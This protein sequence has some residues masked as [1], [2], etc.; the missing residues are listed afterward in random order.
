MK[1]PKFTVRLKMNYSENNDKLYWIEISRGLAALLVV[2]YHAAK[3]T[4]R[5]QSETVEGGEFTH[6]L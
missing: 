4:I 5:E 3:A 1:I 6:Y 2:F